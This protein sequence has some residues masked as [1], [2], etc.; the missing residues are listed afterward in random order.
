[1]LGR[2]TRVCGTVLITFVTSSFAGIFTVEVPADVERDGM[3]RKRRVQVRERR[4]F[5][6]LR[7]AIHRA[8]LRLG[9]RYW[10]VALGRREVDE[11]R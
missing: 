6:L 9:S 2:I 7:R 4:V 1:M 3:A 5:K 8:G 10:D 11:V